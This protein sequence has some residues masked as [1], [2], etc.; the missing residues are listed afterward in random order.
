V[1]PMSLV[2]TPGFK[3]A[4]PERVGGAVT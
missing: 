2:R 3:A 1:R 4:R